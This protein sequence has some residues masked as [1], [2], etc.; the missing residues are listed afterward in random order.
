MKD[1]G[2]VEST[3]KPDAIRLDG[4]SVWIATDITEIAEDIKNESVTMYQY[5]LKQYSKDEYI[6]DMWAQLINVQLAM[7][8]MYETLTEEEL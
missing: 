3:F 1:H 8:D 5:Y 4:Y 6:K 7:C 2:I